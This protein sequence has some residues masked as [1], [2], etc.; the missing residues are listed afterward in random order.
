M[1][2]KLALE[3]K[4]AL[5]FSVNSMLIKYNFL[6]QQIPKDF[7]V[8]NTST[9]RKTYNFSADCVSRHVLHPKFSAE[10]EFSRGIIKFQQKISFDVPYFEVLCTL[11]LSFLDTSFPTK[12]IINIFNN[13]FAD[14]NLLPAEQELLGKI[15]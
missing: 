11:D 5:N 4:L 14:D 9:Y 3:D 7:I 12:D 8:E 10:V 15:K 13:Q 2:V 1:S 6:N